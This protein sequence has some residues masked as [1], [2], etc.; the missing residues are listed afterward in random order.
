MS[1][2]QA[3][4]SIETSDGTLCVDIFVRSDGSFGFEEYRKDPED[5]RGWFPV[6]GYSDLHYATASHAIKAATNSVAW[7]EATVSS[8]DELN[9]AEKRRVGTR[10]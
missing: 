4:R 6:G 1:R 7:L 10:P 8:I 9:N 2:P 5:R 3:L